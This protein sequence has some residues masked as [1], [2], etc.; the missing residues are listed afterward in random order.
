MFLGYYLHYR[1]MDASRRSG[2]FHKVRQI[3][4]PFL[5]LL[6]FH[7]YLA[8]TEFPAAYGTRAFILGPV[9]TGSLLIAP[10]L[11]YFAGKVKPV[12][13]ASPHHN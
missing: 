13:L 9:R 2:L 12:T 5:V 6:G 10:L 3:F 11:Y 4:I 7:S 1:Q 8:M